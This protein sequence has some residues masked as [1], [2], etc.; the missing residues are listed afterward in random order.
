MRASN[1]ETSVPKIKGRAPKF[2][3]HR[4]PVVSVEE[5]QSELMQRKPRL[6]D[7]FP[8]HQDHDGKD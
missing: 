2:A 3:V 4:I 7:Q 1:D 5:R 8:D 6:G